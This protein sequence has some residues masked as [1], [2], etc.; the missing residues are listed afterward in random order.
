MTTAVEKY[1]EVIH[2]VPQLF[3]PGEQFSYNNAGYCVLGRLVEVL[4]EKSY[5]ACLRDHLFTPL[6]LTHAATGPYEAILF[7]AAVG[8]IQ[9]E[10][11]ARWRRRR[12]GRSCAPTPRPARCSPCA[13]ATCWPSPP[14]T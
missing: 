12:C 4:R 7:R 9:S 10:P 6:G 1:L 14:C 5:D 11:R 3:P 13:P 8:H 2:D